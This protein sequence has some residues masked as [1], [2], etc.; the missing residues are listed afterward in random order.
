MI[1][2]GRCVGHKDGIGGRVDSRKER[3][4]ER[5]SKIETVLWKLWDL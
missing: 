2:M 1:V 4:K 5:R 3:Y